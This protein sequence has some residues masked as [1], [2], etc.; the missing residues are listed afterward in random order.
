MQR[1]LIVK[2][3]KSLASL[4][5]RENKTTKKAVA[6]DI[7]SKRIDISSETATKFILRHV[8]S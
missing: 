1:C 7:K 3:I 2:K 5:Y 6:K 4:F 8:V